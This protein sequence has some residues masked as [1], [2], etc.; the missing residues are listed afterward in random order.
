MHIGIKSQLDAVKILP[1]R[2]ISRNYTKA[3]LRAKEGK[4]WKNFI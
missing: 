2:D 1:A 3:L 4:I